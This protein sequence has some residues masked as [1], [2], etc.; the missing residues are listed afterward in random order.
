[1]ATNPVCEEGKAPFEIP[2]IDESCFT[3]Y[4]IVGDLSSGTTP[5]LVLHGDLALATII[6]YDQI[7]CASSTHLRQKAGDET[8]WQEQLFQDELDNLIDHIGLRSGPG[9]HL[10][11]QS[12]GGMLGSAF[13]SRRPPGLRKLIL[14]GAL[15]ST[16][17]AVRGTDLLRDQMPPLLSQALGSALQ[18]RDLDGVG[19]KVGNEYLQKT[20]VCRTKPLPDDLLQAFQNIKDDNTVYSSMMGPTYLLRGGSLKD[21]TVV[22]R[23]SNI[24]APT[25]VIN[26]EYDTSHDIAQAPFFNI[27]PRVRWVQI[28]GGGHMCHVEGEGRRDKVL[29]LVGDFLTEG[30]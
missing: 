14:A 20:H 28:A 21:W 25:L 23:L 1:M 8:F 3:Y 30:S 7:G 12:W 15:A 27:I 6:F 26:G 10:L 18:T 2:S 5:L 4:K 13:A 29:K 19:F 11:G 16:E 24:T 22:P 17:L 9:F